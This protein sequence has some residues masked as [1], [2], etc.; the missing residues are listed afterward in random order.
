MCFL[1]FGVPTVALLV[2]V[3]LSLLNQSNQNKNRH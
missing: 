3:S 2:I 1:V